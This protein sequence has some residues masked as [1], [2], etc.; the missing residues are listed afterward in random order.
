MNSSI[1]VKYI[2]KKVLAAVPSTGVNTMP[3]AFNQILGWASQK[4]LMNEHAELATVFHDSFRITSPD[5]VRM[6][7]GIM[8]DEA[9]N[10]HVVKSVTIPQGRYIIGRFTI[11]MSEFEQAW[12]SMFLWMNE[13]GYQ[14]SA[15]DP[16]EIYYNDYRTHPEQKC[17]C[18]LFIPI[19]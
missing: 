1:E 19:L 15:S 7:I 4:G 14:K 11:L 8:V 5:Q 17:M 3:Q 10:D 9:A 2:N 12:T 6:S 18:D 13:N 16:Y